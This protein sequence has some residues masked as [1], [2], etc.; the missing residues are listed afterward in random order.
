MISFPLP[1]D[2]FFY[3][4]IKKQRET[5]KEINQI[6]QIEPNRLELETVRIKGTIRFPFD[7]HLQRPCMHQ[8]QPFQANEHFSKFENLF[9]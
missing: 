4:K 6:E 7:L 9:F 2:I 5:T 8:Q 1:F 3:L